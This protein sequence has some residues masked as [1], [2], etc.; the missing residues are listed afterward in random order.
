MPEG[1]EKSFDMISELIEV[2]GKNIALKCV[3]V[4]RRWSPLQV[5][6]LGADGQ[7]LRM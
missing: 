4:A 6:T 3:R 5:L 2:M 7:G 1:W